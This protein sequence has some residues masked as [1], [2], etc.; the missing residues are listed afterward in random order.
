M[1]IP[2]KL[3]E[4]IKDSCGPDMDPGCEL[5]QRKCASLLKI[6]FKCPREAEGGNLPQTLNISQLFNL[7]TLIGLFNPRPGGTK[8]CSSLKLLYGETPIRN[9]VQTEETGGDIKVKLREEMKSRGTF[10]D[11]SVS[12]LSFKYPTFDSSAP[13][14]WRHDYCAHKTLTWET[15]DYVLH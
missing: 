2:Q 9:D 12:L 8:N 14:A 1:Q 15:R 7:S 5:V 4:R 3:M 6:S 10:R 13:L 11:S